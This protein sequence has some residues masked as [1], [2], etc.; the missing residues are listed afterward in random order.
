M[1]HININQKKMDIAI[2]ISD[3][4]N[5][6]ISEEKGLHNGQWSTLH[7]GIMILMCVYS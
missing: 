2:F 4:E 5:F 3:G 7:E 6:R 1:Y